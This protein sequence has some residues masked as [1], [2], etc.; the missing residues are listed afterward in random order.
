MPK[1]DWRHD[2]RINSDLFEDIVACLLQNEHPLATK[3]RIS[4]G[5]GGVDVLAPHPEGG[6]TVYQ[7]KFYRN[8]IHWSQVEDS[9]NDVSCTG[10]SISSHDR[11]RSIT[12]W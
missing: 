7:C 6:W 4:R 9:L 12:T 2:S 5:D 10:R 11:Q 3:I 1:I 8:Q